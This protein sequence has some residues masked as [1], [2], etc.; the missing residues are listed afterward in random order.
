[1]SYGTVCLRCRKYAV[2]AAQPANEHSCRCVHPVLSE[3]A[4]NPND[5]SDALRYP[6]VIADAAARARA[7]GQGRYVKTPTPPIRTT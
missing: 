5:P 3:D 6:D 2:T 4:I 7:K 1:M